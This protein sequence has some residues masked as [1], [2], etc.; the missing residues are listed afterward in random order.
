MPE[1]EVKLTNEVGLHARPAAVF[2]KAAAGFSADIT[3]A[4]GGQEANAKSIMAVLKLDVK[5]GDAVTI[6]TEGADAE[7][8]LKELVTLLESL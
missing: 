2:S 3:V 6:A 4:K 7:E 1:K 8:A 5:K